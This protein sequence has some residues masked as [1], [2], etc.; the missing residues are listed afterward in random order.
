MRKERALH[1]FLLRLALKTQS[2]RFSPFEPLSLS[3]ARAHYL[4][5]K[6]KQG[7]L[8]W[9]LLRSRG[10]RL[11]EA[12]L[13]LLR[14]EEEKGKEAEG[15]RR[16]QQR[17]KRRRRRPCRLRLRQDARARPP[18]RRRRP[19]LRALLQRRGDLV[20]RPRARAEA[21]LLGPRGP[22]LV[23]AA[24]AAAGLAV[25]AAGLR[26]RVL[27]GAAEEEGALFPLC[28]VSVGRGGKRG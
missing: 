28:G 2:S 9:P 4:Q 15:G 16:R 3:R 7:P 1:L 26:S 23:A 24:D 17:Q 10:T 27:Q 21:G 6:K 14:A 12:P 5:R 13:R 25:L 22:A 19:H 11:A 18:R 20:H 8:R